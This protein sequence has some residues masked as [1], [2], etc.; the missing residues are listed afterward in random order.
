MFESAPSQLALEWSRIVQ[1]SQ[2][3]S[4]EESSPLMPLDDALRPLFTALDR[5][6]VSLSSVLAQLSSSSSLLLTLT[7]TIER[8]QRESAELRRQVVE[9]KEGGRGLVQTHSL[10]DICGVILTC[11]TQEELEQVYSTLAPAIH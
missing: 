11:S 4:Q 7:H 10:Q 3:Q 8:K 2:N 9:S 1:S 5:T 6:E